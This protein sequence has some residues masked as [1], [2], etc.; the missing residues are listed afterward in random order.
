MSGTAPIAT[1]VLE[2]SAPRHGWNN[3]H[4]IT[5][6]KG[7]VLVIKEADIFAIHVNVK[8]TSKLTILI[9]KTIQ[10]SWEMSF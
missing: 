6:Y 1:Q 7:G 8:K 3:A 4:L 5:R 10:Y 2:C 9:A